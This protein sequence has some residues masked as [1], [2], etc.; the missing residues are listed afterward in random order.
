MGCRDAAF[1]ERDPETNDWS[2]YG[3]QYLSF[4]VTSETLGVYKVVMYITKDG[5]LWTN[6]FAYGYLFNI[7][8]VAAGK[9]IEYAKEN[10]TKAEYEPYQDA[11]VG[12]IVE[13][14]DGYIL[15]DDTV[16]C[17]NPS[18]GTTYKVLLNDL[19]ISRYVD[20]SIIKV[21]NTVQIAYEGKINQANTIDSAI[22]AS[23]VTILGEDAV[24][25]E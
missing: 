7:G 22:S 24:I 16:L 17:N 23:H 8:E 21:G 25:L 3:R 14:T 11:I 10:S 1:M 5:Y 4:T 15:I 6:A 20:Y 13:I 19:R 9:I 12:K 2:V 18:D